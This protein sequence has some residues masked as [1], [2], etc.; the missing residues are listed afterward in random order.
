MAR[1]SNHD[2]QETGQNCKLATSELCVFI[3]LFVSWRKRKKEYD[4]CGVHVCVCY[5]WQL[6]VFLDASFL[7]IIFNTKRAQNS[8]WLA[9]DL[10]VQ[11]VKDLHLLAWL[12][13]LVTLDLFFL[14]LWNIINP[15]RRDTKPLEVQVCGTSHADNRVAYR[16]GQQGYTTSR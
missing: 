10:C 2:Q 1:P 7:F 3:G 11:K 16:H 6:T 5:S 8:C 9:D 13:V 4:I 12:I 14:V 15:L